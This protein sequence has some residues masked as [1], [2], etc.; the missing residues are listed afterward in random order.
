MAVSDLADVVP[1]VGLNGSGKS[2]LLRALNLFFNDEL[3]P[4][5]QF[6]L[7]RDFRE[8]GRKAK[9]RTAIEVDLDFGVFES[10]RAEYDEALEN[11]AAGELLTLRKE[12]T[13]HPVT[14]EEVVTLWAGF[15]EENL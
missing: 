14:R 2:N 10:L 15:D 3:E 6:S 4:G 1:I 12:W 7:R 8:P 5:E 13:L 9:L 11:L